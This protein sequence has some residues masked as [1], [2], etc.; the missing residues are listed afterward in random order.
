MLLSPFYTFLLVG[1][2]KHRC[3]SWRVFYI[4]SRQLL[5]CV[6]LTPTFLP[7]FVLTRKCLTECISRVLSRD[8]FRAPACLVV[9][10][11]LHCHIL[12][13]VV[14]LYVHVAR[15]HH[16]LPRSTNIIKFYV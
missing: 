5:H 11:Y 3:G 4:Q 6:T 14:C 7:E 9:T 12:L 1:V 2:S 15:K 10:V 16:T 8:F 13:R